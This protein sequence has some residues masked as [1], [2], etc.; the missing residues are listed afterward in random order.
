MGHLLAIDAGT[1]G[2]CAVVVSDEGRPLAAARR[3]WTHA[4]DP[5]HPGSVDF[6]TRAAWAMIGDCVRES[7]AGVRAGDVRGVSATSVR[8]GLVLFDAAGEELWA[9]G[10]TDARAADQVRWVR[11]RDPGFEAEAYRSSGQ[12]LAMAALPRLLWLRDRLPCVYEAASTLGMISD[13]ILARLGGEHAADPANACTTGLFSLAGRTWAPELASRW[14]LRTDLLPPVVEPGTPVG[15]VAA[16]AAEVTGLAAGTPVVMGGGDAQAAALGLGVVRPGQAAVVGGT[17]WQQ[18]VNLDQPTT[19]PEGRVR[20]TCHVLGGLWQ[21]EAIALGAGALVRWFL[22]AF[23]APNG[24]GG[25]A[26]AAMAE[27]AGRVPPGAAGVLAI[28][29][30]AFDYQRWRHAAPSLLNLPVADPP[31]TRA[32]VFR[33]LLESAALVTR[34][35]LATIAAAAGR[36]ASV[37]FGGGG[38][39]SPLWAQLLADVLRT[40]VRVPPVAEASALGAAILAGVGVGAFDD[41]ATT[42]A[43]LAA[44][45]RVHEPD[46]AAAAAYDDCFGRWRRAY[47]HQLALADQGVTTPLWRAPGQA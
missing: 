8:G 37:A 22:D 34:A 11:R 6:D 10:S 26:F 16:A 25:D 23:C 32:L 20:V 40:D 35:N 14:G 45:G 42:A 19:D 7:L 3:R 21:A 33:A 2:C 44:G 17:H 47:E 29:A 5:E 43:A 28:G 13:W 41:A 4:A 38:A 46:A 39:R 12:T 15:K 27:R 31:A 1:S 9:C 36:P 30:N 18:L 24:A